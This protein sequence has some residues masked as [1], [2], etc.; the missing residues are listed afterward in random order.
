LYFILPGIPLSSSGVEDRCVIRGLL[1][2]ASWFDS[3]PDP[4]LRL[5]RNSR[6]CWED[7]Y[8]GKTRRGPGWCDYRLNLVMPVSLNKDATAAADRAAGVAA[9]VAAMRWASST[10]STPLFRLSF[11]ICYSACCRTK[12]TRKSSFS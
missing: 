1:D 12:N 2:V 3:I 8:L 6:K 11:L 7:T 4:E 9:A 5:L 10:V